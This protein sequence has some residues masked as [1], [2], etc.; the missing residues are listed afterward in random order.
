MNVLNVRILLAAYNGQKFLAEQLDSLLQQDY[1]HIQ[2]IVSDD[3]SS[4]T[5]ASI[6]ESYASAHPEKI[7]H[8]R[9]GRRFGSA[10]R[11][12]MHLLRTFYDTPYLMF[13]DQDDVWH[14]DK[15]SKTLHLMQQSESDSVPCLIHTDLRVVNGQLEP[16]SDSFCAHSGINGHRLSLNQLLVQNVVTGCTVMIN[17]PLAEL[18]CR[19]SSDEDMLMHDW[20]LALLASCCGKIRF[21]EEA[22]IDYRQ[23]G[24][25]AVGAKNVHSPAY[26]L[27]RLRSNSMRKALKK[28]ST[29]AKAFRETFCDRLSKSQLELLDAFITTK[30]ANIFKR[31]YL[32]LKYKL[33]KS[34]LI[35]KFAQLLGL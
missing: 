4:D 22:T 10:Q 25:N 27:N 30:D 17:R 33:L 9:S 32:Y 7:I 14:P 16:I 34:G 13:C 3:G 23:H 6:L 35:R 5:T 19:E 2:I 21:L 26:L 28:T 29:Q 24:S 12:F 31:D 15:V 11:H 1:P 20:W 18:A 8:Y